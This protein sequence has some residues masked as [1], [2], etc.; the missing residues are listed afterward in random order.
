M[1]TPASHAASARAVSRDA[2]SRG[3]PYFAARTGSA[4]SSVWAAPGVPR[5]TCSRRATVRG[6]S[7]CHTVLSPLPST[8]VA[9]SSASSKR[10]ATTSPVASVPRRQREDSGETAVV[11]EPEGRF[12]V[13][14][15]LARLAV[16]DVVLDQ[17][18]PRPR[19]SG[20]LETGRISSTAARLQ[21]AHTRRIS[22]SS[23]SAPHRDE[24]MDTRLLVA[25][26]FGELEAEPT[27]TKA[28]LIAPLDQVESR[29]GPCTRAPAPGNH[30][31]ARA[32]RCARRRRGQCR[33]PSPR[34]GAGTAIAE[35]CT[36]SAKVTRLP[37]AHER[38]GAHLRPRR[39]SDPPRG[40]RRRT[41]RAA[42][43]SPRPA[44]RRR[45]AV[46][47]RTPRP[48]PGEI[49]ASPPFAPP[50]GRNEALRPHRRPARRGTRRRQRRQFRPRPVPRGC[51]DGAG[52]A[53]RA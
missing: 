51:G 27:E 26:L 47:A 11:H 20:S 30:R 25:L 13:H 24:E 45:T 50:R 52:S 12:C 18:V 41:R 6:S 46:L 23:T 32:P 10:P 16:R 39:A 8:E 9:V 44:I 14:E 35:R 34:L 2:R 31:A 29:C 21:L 15:H 42:L 36:Q 53:A 40:A 19:P 43:P 48:P 3:S 4:S 38:I 37:P 5:R 7:R 49:P 17:V 33:S 1:E 28:L 22:H